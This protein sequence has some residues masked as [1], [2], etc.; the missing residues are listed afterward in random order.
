M[1]FAHIDIKR[2]RE[3]NL[4]PPPLF[5]FFIQKGKR[6]EAKAIDRSY[7]RKKTE[8]VFRIQKPQN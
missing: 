3:E 7:S 4:S 5:F 1:T 2:T 8:I 6:M